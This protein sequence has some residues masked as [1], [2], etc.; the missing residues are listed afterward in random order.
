MVAATGKFTVLKG[1]G[2]NTNARVVEIRDARQANQTGDIH[3]YN[4]LSSLLPQDSTIWFQ[5]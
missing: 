4:Y 1:Y 2:V 3:D 5:R